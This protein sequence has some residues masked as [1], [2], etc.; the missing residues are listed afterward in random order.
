MQIKQFFLLA[1]MGLIGCS[2]QHLSTADGT[3]LTCFNSPLT[4][5]AINHPGQKQQSIVTRVKKC[6][7]LTAASRSVFR[8]M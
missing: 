8:P 5:E 6:R 3:C 1:G 2:G 7:E 4:G